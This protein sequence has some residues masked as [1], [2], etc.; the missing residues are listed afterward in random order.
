[1]LQAII[2]KGHVFAEEISAPQLTENNVLIKVCYSCI[3]AGT[4]LSSVGMSGK[5]LYKRALEQPSNV[6]KVVDMAKTIGIS[7]TIAKVKGVLDGGNTTGYSVS[8]IVLAVGKNVKNIFPGD[9]V[10]AAGAGY[11]HHAEFVEVPE[12][13]VMKVPEGLSLKHASTVTLGGIAL[14]GVR[15]SD[16]RLGENCLVVGAGILGLLTA[17]ILK[18]SG[19]RVA[20]SDLD[21]NRL[22]VARSLG[23]DLV[24]NPASEKTTELI[25]NWTSGYGVDAVIFTAATSSSAPLS[26]SF[27]SCKKK[28]RVVLVGVSGMEI[29]REDIYQKEI[30]FLISSSYGPGRYDSNYEEK[31]FDYPYAFVRWTENRNMTEYLRLIKDGKINVDALINGIFEIEKVEEAYQSL[32]TSSPKPLIVLLSYGDENQ[33]VSMEKYQASSKKVMIDNVVPTKNKINYALIGAGGFATG[34]H[35]PNLEKQNK[36]FNLLAVVNKTGHKAKVAA[37]QY[38]A[39]YASS[40]VEDVMKDDKVNMLLIATRHDSHAELVMKGLNA[41]KHVFVEKPLAVNGLQLNE[42]LEFYKTEQKNKPALMVGFNRRFSPLIREINEHSKKRTN[43]LMIY[44]RMNAGFVPK[45]S[46]IHEDGG[47]IVGECCHIIDLMTFLTGSEVESVLSEKI[48][49]TNEKL[50]EDDNCSITIKFKDGS[51]STI[52]YFANGSKELAKEYMELHFDGKSIVMNDYKSL[53]GYGLS[54]KSFDLKVSNKGQFEEMEAWGDYLKNG[55][56]WPIKLWELEQTT[57][58]SFAVQ[59]GDF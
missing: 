12:N 2:K 55:G 18:A 43:P 35:L 14:Q 39:A 36:T 24:F 56:E 19:V 44:Y 7:K 28:G 41:G 1:M 8:G 20:V 47:R 38:G 5:P 29:K 17:Q 57:R 6:A 42:I 21:E 30:D 10:A 34:M 54:I 9:L 59:Y 51:I 26:D 11:A 48:R 23:I 27:K 45:E 40:D 49:P 22:A 13:L 25:S 46:W 33:A 53:E 3:S 31:G 15:R 16:L 32:Q 50:M 52:H 37:K 58:I 4:E